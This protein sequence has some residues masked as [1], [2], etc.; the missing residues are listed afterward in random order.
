MTRDAGA[1]TPVER[2]PFEAPWQAQVFALT[3][4][5][6]ESGLFTW[7]EWAAA[8]AARVDA[9]PGPPGGAADAYYRQWAAALEDLLVARRVT[10]AAAVADLEDAWQA[11]AARTPHGTPIVLDDADPVVARAVSGSGS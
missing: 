8:L 1:T 11:A 9:D 5:L 6:H 3:V 10:T 4:S 2:S 7:P